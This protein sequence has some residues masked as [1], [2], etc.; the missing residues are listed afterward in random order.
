MKKIII[1]ILSTGMIVLA[2]SISSPTRSESLRHAKTKSCPVGMVLVESPDNRVRICVDKFETSEKNLFAKAVPF[3]NQNYYSC[4]KLC[5]RSGKRLLSHKEWRVSCLGTIPEKC[6]KYRKH[7]VVKRIFMNG[8]WVYNGKNCKSK[9]N[10][11]GTC[12]QDPSINRMANS[13]ASNNKFEQCVS[14]YGVVNM[15]GNL[16]EWVSDVRV[17]EGKAYG[18]FNGGLYAQKRSSCGYTTTAH[19]LDYRDYSLGCRCAK[20]LDT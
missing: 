20:D 3:S 15:V 11:W 1:C 8:A 4:Q 17:I 6:N 12:L 9:E 16:G 7:P 10:A 14:K 19:S 2:F 5:A 13:L 18:R